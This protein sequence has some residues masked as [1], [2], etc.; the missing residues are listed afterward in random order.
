MKAKKYWILAMVVL[1]G[2]GVLLAGSKNHSEAG[3][4]RRSLKELVR[5][6]K[7]LVRRTLF[8]NSTPTADE[9]DTLKGLEGIG[10]VVKQINPEVEKYGLRKQQ[11]QTDVEL[12]LRQNGIRVFS[13]EEVLSTPGSPYLSVNVSVFI[14]ADGRKLAAFKINIVLRQKVYLSRDLKIRCDATTWGTSLVG[15]GDLSN[16][17]TIREYVKDAVDEFINDYLAAN[18]K[19]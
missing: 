7:E 16:L 17:E 6:K 5:K 11:I 9:R 15:S 1:V 3:E 4:P 18:P 14:R 8:A 19:K 10:V 13:P 12:R 2:V